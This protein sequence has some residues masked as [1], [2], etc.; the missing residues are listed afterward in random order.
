MTGA[1]SR[2][3]LSVVVDPLTLE[4]QTCA[5]LLEVLAQREQR[6][7]EE[8][9][10]SGSPEAA[11]K[12]VAFAN[13]VESSFFMGGSWA[14][15]TAR[16]E[17][18]NADSYESLHSSQSVVPQAHSSAG[19]FRRIEEDFT[20][21]LKYKGRPVS[22]KPLHFA[23]WWCAT[24]APLGAPAGSALSTAIQM[25]D[26]VLVRLLLRAMAN[27]QAKA[28]YQGRGNQTVELGAMHIAAGLGCVP[29]LQAL[30]DT[31]MGEPELMV[32]EYC[33]MG[34]AHFYTPLHDAAF[35][36][37]QEAVQWLLEN[38]ANPMLKNI[39]GFTPLHWLAYRGLDREDQV[40]GIVR[41]LLKS[42]ASLDSRTSDDVPETRW[43]NLIPLELSVE[44]G[45]QFPK[46]LLYL[47]AP[48][49]QVVENPSCVQATSTRSIFEDMALM[50]A[51]STEA[52]FLFAQKI[53]NE[54]GESARVKIVIDAQREHAVGSIASLFHMAPEAATDL[55]N[56][57]T[58]SPH[59]ADPGHHPLS[60]R[61]ILGSWWFA[62]NSMTS[63][64]EPDRTSKRMGDLTAVKWPEWKYDAAKAAQGQ[65]GFPAW[66]NNLVR[67][68]APEN[69]RRSNVSDVEYSVLL[70][71]NILDHDIF[72]ALA[73]CQPSADK[74]FTSLSVRGAIHCLWVNLISAVF[75]LTLWLNLLE[76]VCL[77][78]WGLTPAGRATGARLFLGPEEPLPSPSLHSPRFSSVLAAGL[79]RDILNLLWWYYSLCKNWRRH[80]RDWKEGSRR[81]KAMQ[82]GLH[83]LWHPSKALDLSHNTTMPELVLAAIKAVFLWNVGPAVQL[84]TDE[85]I[86]MTG[87]QV[88]LLAL[89]LFLQCGKLIYMLRVSSVSGKKILVLLKTL[90]SGAM[91]EMMLVALLVFASFFLTALI[92]SKEFSVGFVGVALFR[93]LLF[94]EGSGLDALGFSLV[95]PEENQRTDKRFLSLLSLMG[96]LSF[97]VVILNLIVAIYSNTYGQLEENS[98]L[99]FQKERAK[100][101]CM[102][103]LSL[104][105]LHFSNATAQVWVSRGVKLATAAALATAIA[106]WVQRPDS[107]VAMS[108][109]AV[110]AA[111]A[112]VSLQA[113]MMQSVW[114]GRQKGGTEGPPEDHF[115]WICSK[116]D[117]PDLSV[118]AY[119]ARFEELDE[120]LDMLERITG[121]I[122]RSIDEKFDALF[123]KIESTSPSGHTVCTQ[124]LSFQLATPNKTKKFT[125]GRSSLQLH[126]TRDFNVLNSDTCD[127]NSME[128]QVGP[129]A[130][131]EPFCI[132][133]EPGRACHSVSPTIWCGSTARP[134]GGSFS[135][136]S[137]F[138]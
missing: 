13:F 79:L 12:A 54:G 106:L 97:V 61:A 102:C 121:H 132:T 93:G 59:V 101:S 18:L 92:L 28:R 16:P 32:N 69:V 130:S 31:S 9:A 88:T 104:Q 136:D 55:L 113:I 138:G 83:A 126:G 137:L 17:V 110:L 96:A 134:G 51:R 24:K 48:S 4:Q 95:T 65:A 109:A 81:G 122:S 127:V 63:A 56:M 10:S 27:P 94:G 111:L 43:R 133:P 80:L 76:L 40:E 5:E 73:S 131:A 8:Q 2:E 99:L 42:G 74:V 66:H 14:R 118:S 49:F 35:C 124:D 62:S 47:L 119:S 58:D 85:T 36:G 115:L 90:L 52:A 67:A 125:A 39:D 78:V 77:G 105:K 19:L 22:G 100:Y 135:C 103:L 15:S 45:S 87:Q 60:T 44:P 64:Y 89:N 68:P 50:S 46:R 128:E 75:V 82:A 41:L 34:G 129:A 84:K 71:P 3:K 33:T 112:Q 70:L 23:V 53:H 30:L 108:C 120:R 72:M 123:K 98:E 29:A 6:W 57:L 1:G 117:D 7:L 114:F 37:K 116:T 26:A 91:R 107:A 86:E 11:A 38:T 21:L 25:Q 20:D